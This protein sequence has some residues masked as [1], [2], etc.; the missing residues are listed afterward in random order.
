MNANFDL[1]IGNY[2]KNELEEI[3]GLP[4]NYDE[5]VVEMQETK[6]RQN[7]LNDNSIPATIKTKTLNFLESFPDVEAYIVY[8]DKNGKFK[9]YISKEMES[10]IVNY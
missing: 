4:I 3:L 6:M 2:S 8:S 9:T 10:R 1:N 5:S 7:I